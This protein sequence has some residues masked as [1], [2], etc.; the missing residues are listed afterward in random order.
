M[1]QLRENSY[2]E[3]R[4]YFADAAKLK[5]SGLGGEQDESAEATTPQ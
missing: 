3:R 1:D 5:S 4:G 2:I